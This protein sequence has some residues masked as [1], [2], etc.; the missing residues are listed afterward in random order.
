MFR[1]CFVTPR[2]WFETVIAFLYSHFFQFIYSLMCLWWCG[3]CS[4]KNVCDTRKHKWCQQVCCY[5]CVTPDNEK[6]H[7]L[8]CVKTM[9]G[10]IF[11]ARFKTAISVS[12]IFCQSL[13]QALPILL[14][15]SLTILNLCKIYAP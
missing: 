3:W 12:R 14:V 4:V 15:N 10:R 9:T 7:R 11:A 2:Y 1:C 13:Y 5:R 6:F 8:S